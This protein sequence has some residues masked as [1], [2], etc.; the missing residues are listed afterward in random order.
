MHLH[1]KSVAQ[2]AA[3]CVGHRGRRQIARA[4]DARQENVVPPVTVEV[5]W[6]AWRGGSH[7]IVVRPTINV[8]DLIRAGHIPTECLP[9]IV[10]EDKNV[11]P[12]PCAYRAQK[13]D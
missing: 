5:R 7:F 11:A 9:G 10:E 12:T 13:V 8:I 4:C 6:I 2:A 3:V 1:E